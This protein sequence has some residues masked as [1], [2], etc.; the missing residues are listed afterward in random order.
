[1]EK[2][3]GHS[4][5]AAEQLAEDYNQLEKKYQKAKKLIKEYQQR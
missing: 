3:Q 4:Q 1:M 2:S 5:Q